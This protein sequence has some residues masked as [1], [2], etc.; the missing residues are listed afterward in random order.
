MSVYLNFGIHYL[1]VK[2]EDLGPP[3]LVLKYSI[4]KL[5]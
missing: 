2:S 5:G 4:I 1:F 3:S